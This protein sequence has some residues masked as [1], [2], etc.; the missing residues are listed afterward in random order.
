MTYSIVARDPIT[1]ELGIAV[2]SR[3]FAA[4]RDVPWI[5]A[6][7]GVVASQSFVNPVYGHETLRV[8]RSGMEPQHI[9]KKLV[10]EDPGE[11]MRQVAILDMQGRVAVHTGAKCV[12]AAG[13]TN[14]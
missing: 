5:E 8:L 1:S 11:A 3:Y 13:H 9:L 6:G 7:V 4:G 12:P 10:S 2:Q 14:C